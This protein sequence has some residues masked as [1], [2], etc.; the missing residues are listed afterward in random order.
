MRPAYRGGY[1][2]LEHSWLGMKKLII[3]AALAAVLAG[4]ASAQA[5]SAVSIR[6]IALG[7]PD[8]IASAPDANGVVT[9]SSTVPTPVD[10]T[11][12]GT[13]IL[14]GHRTKTVLL[15]A[16]TYTLAQAG[17]TGFGSGWG[18]CLLASGGTALVNA[19]TSLF[20][21]ASGTTAL[22]LPTGSWVCLSSDGTNY[23]SV[24]A[25]F[26]AALLNVADQVVVGGAN[27][28]SL[29]Q[30]AGNLT[31]DCG[32]RPSQY[33]P[34]SGAFTI[35]APANDGSCYL[36][37]ENGGTAGAITLSGFS[38]NSMGGAVLDTTNGHN[39]RLVISR[40]HAHSTIYAVALQ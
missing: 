2:A 20:V 36:D 3:A 33:I 26:S 18:A 39:F 9:V 4:T 38:P 10:L 28:T 27:I 31:I 40:V 11:S 37:V 23:T 22:T 25:H 17:T 30:S 35:T 5:P 24:S 13:A 6:G 1:D 21:G 7:T 8:L 32:A 19:T 15:G 16:H 34:N 29:S 14:T 12:A